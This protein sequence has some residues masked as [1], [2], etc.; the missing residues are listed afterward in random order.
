MAGFLTNMNMLV[1]SNLSNPSGKAVRS[2]LNPV[3]F[4]AWQASLALHLAC[5]VTIGW[6]ESVDPEL[7]FTGSLTA[8]LW[9]RLGAGALM[10]A[11]SIHWV[12]GA[13]NIRGYQRVSRTY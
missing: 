8:L 13:Q 3:P 7:W 2:I 5:L 9:A 12:A 10:V 6:A 11:V 4:Y 1:L